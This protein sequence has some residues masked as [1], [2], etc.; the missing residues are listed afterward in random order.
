MI[1]PEIMVSPK[2]HSITL[3][4][5]K[6]SAEAFRFISKFSCSKH[7]GEARNQRGR[8]KYCCYRAFSE[9]LQFEAEIVTKQRNLHMHKLLLSDQLL[10][11]CRIVGSKMHFP[12][13]YVLASLSGIILTWPAVFLMTLKTRNI[14]SISSSW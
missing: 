2:N 14:G 8:A 12:F 3:L 5:E 13:T 1:K 4:G 9:N 11:W 10:T 7:A 6:N